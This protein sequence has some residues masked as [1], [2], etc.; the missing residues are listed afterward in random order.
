MALTTAAFTNKITAQTAA[1]ATWSLASDGS[2]VVNAVDPGAITAANQTLGSAVTTAGS[3][4]YGQ[5]Y[6]GGASTNWQRLPILPNGFN[7]DFYVEYKVTASAGK[8]LQV[9]EI[10]SNLL[11]SG[12]SNFVVAAYSLNAFTT[13]NAI[14]VS[15]NLATHNN[16]P[17][18]PSV[19]T[20]LTTQAEPLGLFNANV[21]STVLGGREVLT[22][23]NLQINV[24]PGQT[25]S[26]RIYSYQNGTMSGRFT[27]SR[28]MVI[29]G[30]TNT[31]PIPLPLD[32]LSFNTQ[33]TTGF[34]K[35]VKLN[36]STTNEVN[37]QKFI[38]ERNTGSNFEA[39]GEI[40]SN[41]TTGIHYYT[42]TDENPAKETA[43]YRLKQVDKDGLYKYSVVN[44]VNNSSN[45][46]LSSY[47]NPIIDVV[48]IMHPKAS[49]DAI[50]NI[51]D[52]NGRKIKVFKPH[53]DS[54]LTTTNLSE[55]KSGNFLLTLDNDGE[56]SAI[57]IIKK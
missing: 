24:N 5:T 21:A 47:P 33:L 37:T 18:V 43:Y 45:I 4:I 30:K 36:W 12:G 16:Q 3:V 23:P 6:E 34:A 28:N 11:G 26:I 49:K 38:I 25:L 56:K 57:K 55:L 19:T 48:N 52:L 22:F 27:A 13:S 44:S 40:N 1:S 9:N 32:F 8:Y 54:V 42:F 14:A 31:S 39:I 41:N 46:I 35:Q 15:P 17:S 53:E 7:A 10:T 50:I 2:V 29:S 51:V 20:S